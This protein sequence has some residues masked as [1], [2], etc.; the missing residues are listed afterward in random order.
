MG[1]ETE[2]KKLQVNATAKTCS[3]IAP[4]LLQDLIYC[5]PQMCTGTCKANNLANFVSIG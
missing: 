3:Q 2:R 1:D 5:V 4:I